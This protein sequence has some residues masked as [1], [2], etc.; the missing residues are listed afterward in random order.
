MV[1]ALR[2]CAIGRAQALRGSTATAPA[3]GPGAAIAREAILSV[4]RGHGAGV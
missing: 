1:R 4:T 2:C 3:P